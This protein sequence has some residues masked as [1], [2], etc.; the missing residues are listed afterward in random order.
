MN[1]TII[2]VTLNPAL[3]KT[4]TLDQLEIGGLNRTK[5]IRIDPGGKGINA[6]KVLKTFHVDVLATGF[7][8]GQTGK[9]L[10]GQLNQLAIPN[11]FVEVNGETRTNLKIVDEDANVTTEINEPGFSISNQEIELFKQQLSQRITPHSVVIFGG[12]LPVNAPTSIY[13]ELIDMT[14]KKGAKTILDAD[15]PALQEGIK[16]KP[17]AIKP[18]LYELE[19][20]LGQTL[21]HQQKILSAGKEIIESGIS[22]VMISMGEQGAIILNAK[23]AYHITPFSITP[24]ST[25]GAGDSMVA[26]L[27]YSL[28]QNKSLEETGLLATTAGTITASKE[29]TQVCTLE[30]IV[31]SIN[32]SKSSN[33]NKMI[34]N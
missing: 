7:I 4:I 21:D 34:K 13:Q 14:N 25:V 28:L 8:A 22:L 26:T 3:D 31:Q 29:G 33:L 12:S 16:A 23:E 1:Q 6:A 32:R 19:Q 9:Q 20:L 5:E 11:H 15:G 24:K 27:A 18:N 2:T 30:E 10:I 17:F